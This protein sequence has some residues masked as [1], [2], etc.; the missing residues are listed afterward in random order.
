M[1]ITITV[2]HFSFA[3]FTLTPPFHTLTHQQLPFNNFWSINHFIHKELSWRKKSP[4]IFKR[5]PPHS[6]RVTALTAPEL[7]KHLTLPPDLAA[8]VTA[9]SL[10]F[11]ASMIPVLNSSCT[12]MWIKQMAIAHFS[13]LRCLNI[14]SSNCSYFFFSILQ[15]SYFFTNH[16]FTY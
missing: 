11:P 16:M 5:S 9:S 15:H 1:Y 8:L 2:Q 12:Q 13:M 4:Q 3:P 6:V 7:T 10:T 14:S